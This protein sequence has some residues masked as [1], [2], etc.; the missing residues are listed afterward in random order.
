MTCKC[1]RP[2]RAGK[3]LMGLGQRT[4]WYCPFAE[5]RRWWNLLTNVFHTEP[6]T[7]SVP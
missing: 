5:E 1:G 7:I 6:I 3:E 4:A 2:M